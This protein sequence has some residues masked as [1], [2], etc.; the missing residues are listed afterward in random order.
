MEGTVREK[1]TWGRRNVTE[2]QAD[3][4]NVPLRSPPINPAAEPALRPLF[5]QWL[6]Q[7]PGD[8]SDRQLQLQ[9]LL[10]V[11]EQISQNELQPETL[12]L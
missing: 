10:L 4:E 2:A 6:S 5:P 1:D 12:S 7:R 11:L 9:E 8:S 3:H